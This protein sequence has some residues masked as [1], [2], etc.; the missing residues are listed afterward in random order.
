MLLRFVEPADYTTTWWIVANL[1]ARLIERLRAIHEKV[2]ALPFLGI[3][4]GLCA[5]LKRCEIV[6]PSGVCLATIAANFSS[7]MPG[8]SKA[9]DLRR[10]G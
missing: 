7:V 10:S 9:I 4:G 1:C 6:A 5:G 8:R 2:G 3:R